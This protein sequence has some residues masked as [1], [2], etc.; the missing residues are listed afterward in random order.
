MADSTIKITLNPRMVQEEPDGSACMACGDPVFLKA[1]RIWI[2]WK[3][4]RWRSKGLVCQ[5]CRDFHQPE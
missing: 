2:T 3:G 4:S 1:F 5:S